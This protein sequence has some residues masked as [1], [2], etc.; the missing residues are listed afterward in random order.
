MTEHENINLFSIMKTFAESTGLTG[1]ARPPRRYLWTDAFAVCNY[2]E[3]YRQSENPDY[4]QLAIKLVDQVHSVLGRNRDDASPLSGL[5]EREAALHPTQA[6]LRIGKKLDERQNNERFDEQLEWERDGQYFHYLTKWM[7]A[8]DCLGRATG[9][10]DYHRWA[11][12]LAR[13]AFSAFTYLPDAGGARRM[14]WKMSIDLSRPLV[15][16]MGHHDP[17][18]GLLTFQ[19]LQA[20]AQ[21]YSETSGAPVLQHEINEFSAMCAGVDWAT[22]DP[23]GIG[24]LLSDAYRLLQLISRYKLPETP[25]LELLLHDI[26]RSMQAF[27][28]TEQQNTL[29]LPAEYRLAFRELGLAIG[30]AAIDKMR[31]ITEENAENFADN[32]RL[33]TRINT[34]TRYHSAYNVIRDFWLDLKHQA[35]NT[36]Q[37]HRDINTVMLATCLSPDAYLTI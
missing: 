26:E 30:L 11:V 4:L 7:H 24:G 35:N 2:I 36:W 34:L 23:L 33:N 8:L 32:N 22:R 16:S 21:L 25:M 28:A 20:T 17:L 5:D 15:P 9:N 37:E 12:E 18:D 31:V 10:A 27:A 19:Q 6:G 3:M 1:C 13:A 14:Y 29:A